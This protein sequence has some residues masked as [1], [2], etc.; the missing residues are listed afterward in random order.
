MADRTLQVTVLIIGGGPSGLRAA[1]DLAPRVDGTV[2]VVERERAAGGIPRHSHHTGFGI[3]DV[4]RS[5]SG[6]RYARLLRKRAELA[7]AR[8]M[9]DTMVTGWAGPLA[10]LATSRR[11]RIRIEAQA[12]VLATGARERP[13]SAR[14][15]P[16]DRASGVYTTG[17]LQNLVDRT[18]APIGKRAVILGT[19]LV[20]WS[21]A[22]TLRSAGCRTAMLVTPR[23]HPETYAVLTA[24][25]TIYLGTTVATGTRLVRVLGRGRV[26]AVELEDLASGERRTVECDTVV[27]TG[28][29]IADNELARALGVPTEPTTGAPIVDETGGTGVYGVFAAGNV[30]HPVAT[31]DIAALSGAHVVDGVLQHLR[32]EEP[33]EGSVTLVAGPGIRWVSPGR[34]SV[35]GLAQPRGRLVLW[36]EVYRSLPR[37]LVRQGGRV[38]ATSRQLLPASPGRVFRIRASL[39]R[40]AAADGGDITIELA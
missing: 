15:I 19:E 18:D 10:V 2:L 16:G 26:E 40:R 14:L 34:V 17:S 37:V 11:G 25:A 8:I 5:L 21:A 38:L 7:G 29:W 36:A 13:R 24:A 20:S 1:A 12:V 39:L 3:R 30:T 9:T 31:A 33:A 6:P 28:D 22:L 32:G 27:L 23:P 4:K 35:R